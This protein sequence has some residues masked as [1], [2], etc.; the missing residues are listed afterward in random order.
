M[1]YCHLREPYRRGKVISDN[2]AWHVNRRRLQR[3][4]SNFRQDKFANKCH[5]NKSVG[6]LARVP[7]KKKISLIKMRVDAMYIPGL[8]YH[9][10][11]ERK[12]NSNQAVYLNPA[13]DDGIQAGV[14][15][16]GD[17]PRGGFLS[18]KRRGPA[19]LSVVPV[20]VGATSGEGNHNIESHSSRR[21][22]PM[23]RPRGER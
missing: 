11:S 22:S 5:F 2:S 7:S 4:V 6:R 10:L 19:E 21:P 16:P 8:K 15:L 14:I 23:Q 13:S 3:L 17:H 12:H 18:A 9:T 20:Q 1:V